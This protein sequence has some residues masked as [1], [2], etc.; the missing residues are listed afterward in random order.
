[1]ALASLTKVM[2]MHADT[3]ALAIASALDRTDEGV[4]VSY[5]P[6]HVGFMLTNAARGRRR[7]FP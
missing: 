1:L 5:N 3:R 6:V 2:A 7:G 4:I